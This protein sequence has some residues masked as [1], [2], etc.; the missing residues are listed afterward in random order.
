MNDS[1]PR[2]DDVLRAVACVRAH[3]NA[4]K[5]GAFVFDVVATQAE[6]RALFAGQKFMAQ[7]ATEHGIDAEAAGT[8]LGNVLSSLERGPAD[9]TEH[10]LVSAFAAQGFVV[11]Y[12]S[13]DPSQ[14][15]AL[16]K[17]LATELAWLE[18]ASKYRLWP[19][20][21]ELAQTDTLAALCSALADLVLDDERAQRDAG[22][23][24]A[25]ASLSRAAARLVMLANGGGDAGREALRRV[26]TSAR[27]APLLRALATALLGEF[28]PPE[29]ATD[30]L[31]VSGEIA[32]STRRPWVSVLRVLT[33][34][35][36]L[37]AAARVPAF[38]LRLRREL[39]LELHGSELR[40]E[41][42]TSLLGRTVRSARAVYPVERIHGATRAGRYALVRTLVGVFSLC[43]GLL[44][45]GYFLFDAA[46]GGASALASAAAIACGLGAG[47]DL[48][49]DVFGSA[50]HARVRLQVDLRDARALCLRG[51]PQADADRFLD[52]LERALAARKI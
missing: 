4:D 37:H 18:T 31:R 1:T 8:E 15:S 25:T 17:K 39:D 34:F 48:A 33:G 6:G 10:A 36:L 9:R 38:L 26:Q 28:V 46:R 11:A 13:A 24:D 51:V 50:L 19:C 45:G 40:A 42:R 7:R 43:A 21:H 30:S 52:A 47:L 32:A 29:T 49:L 35:S 5:L 22:E 44:L 12:A 20:L 23:L 27:A 2:R 3:A 41:R 16:A 14:R